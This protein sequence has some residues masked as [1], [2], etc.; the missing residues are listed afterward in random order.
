M[1]N[2]KEAQQLF[3]D[4]KLQQGE[5]EIRG[6]YAKTEFHKELKNKIRKYILKLGSSKN[7]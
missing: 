1:A 2:N 5:K 6:V 7:E 4:K 3:R